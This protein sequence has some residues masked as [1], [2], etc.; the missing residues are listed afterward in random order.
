MAVWEDLLAKA[1]RDAIS[2]TVNYD[3]RRG[4]Q[5]GESALRFY[6]GFNAKY[7]GNN[8]GNP[9]DTYNKDVLRTKL[10]KL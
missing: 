8:H 7:A 2:A 4:D 6:S 9:L 5:P 1:A 10:P 3:H